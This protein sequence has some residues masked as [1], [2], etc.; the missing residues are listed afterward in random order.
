M[1]ATDATVA[2]S[3]DDAYLLGAITTLF[4]VVVAAPEAAVSLVLLDCGVSRRS[5]DRVASAARRWGSRATLWVEPVPTE[6]LAALPPMKCTA[7]AVRARD[8]IRARRLSRS[9][10]S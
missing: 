3:S 6:P 7:T 1:P 10:P 9:R 5:L 4:S 8:E 2:V